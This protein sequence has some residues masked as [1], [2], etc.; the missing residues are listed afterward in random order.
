M[1]IYFNKQTILLAIGIFIFAG[2]QFQIYW[3]LNSVRES[4]LYIEGGGFQRF[5]IKIIGIS[6]LYVALIRSFS[7]SSFT[8][9]LTIKIPLLYYVATVVV[10]IPV[11]LSKNYLYT[12]EH[13]MAVNLVLFIPLLLINFYGERG[14]ELFSK[15]IRITVWV[16]CIQLLIDLI[17]KFLNFSLV[18]TIL[19]GM[20]NANTFGLHLIIA[21]LG[22]RFIYRKHLLSNIVLVFTWGTGSLICTLV[23][24][25]LLMQSLIINFF[26]RPLM[27]FFIFSS[28]LITFT[29]YGDFF[30]SLFLEEFGPVKHAY[31]KISEVLV[32]KADNVIARI[33][34]IIDAWELMKESPL[35]FIFGHPSFLPFWTTDGFFLAIFVNLGV[36]ALLLFIISNIYL[37]YRGIIEKKPLSM[38]ASY[39]LLVYLAFFCTNRILDYWPSGFIY[40]LIFTYLS[41]KIQFNKKNLYNEK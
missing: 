35:S 14:D 32:G 23:G 27:T 6:L 34:F 21:A 10:L 38:F 2:Y 22:L 13:L 12:A 1:K 8:H 20:G 36:P 25:L 11:F 9:N 29:L 31:T 18:P 4:V 40:V 7:F 33:S 39:T 26:K 37:F 28:V 17:L 15:L 5:L 41:R 16:V 24:T 30:Y 19:G 3:G